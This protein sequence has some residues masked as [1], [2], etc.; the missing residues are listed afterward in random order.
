MAKIK[1][2]YKYTKYEHSKLA[3]AIS[4]FKSSFGGFLGWMGIFLIPLIVSAGIA[5]QTGYAWVAIVV[6]LAVAL[7]SYGCLFFIK[8]EKIAENKEKKLGISS[9]NNNPQF[10]QKPIELYSVLEDKLNQA[11]NHFSDLISRFSKEETLN[12]Y[13]DECYADL[14]TF[15]H[16]FQNNSSSVRISISEET[17]SEDMKKIWDKADIF[18][19]AIS[20]YYFLELKDEFIEYSKTSVF[21]QLKHIIKRNEIDWNKSYQDIRNYVIDRIK[22]LPDVVWKYCEW[23]KASILSVI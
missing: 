18:L 6:I 3:T 8:E 4:M 5:S 13:K 19:D 9:E 2:T 1:I 21:D 20:L 11:K 15:L 10:A 23:N 14:E 12:V 22:R 7:I 17:S 16:L